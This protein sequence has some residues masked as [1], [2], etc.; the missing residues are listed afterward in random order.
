MKVS[1][2]SKRIA[3]PEP[4]IERPDSQQWKM[5][6]PAN[7]SFPDD[8]KEFL[9][10]FGT[11]VIFDFIFIWNPFSKVEGMNFEA[12]STRHRSFL[13]E[14]KAVTPDLFVHWPENLLPFG[15]T[16]N[17]DTLFWVMEGRPNEWEVA[18]SNY[19]PE[20][21]YSRFG[22]VDFLAGILSDSHFMPEALPE[23][24]DAPR[25]FLPILED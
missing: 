15:K 25:T 10:R 4:L 22:M 21:W 8:Y 7:V 2:F 13:K 6:R 18:V 19:S 1:E 23:L 16:E 11:G 20:L 3:T 14:H 9:E 12:E 24:M 5:A 17:G